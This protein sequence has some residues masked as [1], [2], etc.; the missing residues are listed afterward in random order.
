MLKGIIF[1]MDGTL[2][3]TNEY[4]AMAYDRLFRDFG[5]SVTIDEYF[6][7]F[8]GKGS[9]TIITEG[10]DG[11]DFDY[12]KCHAQKVK[13][14]WEIINDLEDVPLI[15]GV[16]DFLDWV[17]RSELRMVVASG[18]AKEAIMQVL[19]RAGIINY[20]ENYFSG[21]EMAQNKPAPDVYI[22]ALRFLDLEAHEVLAFEDSMAG[23]KSSTSAGIKTIGLTT[24]NM[25]SDL[26]S[27]GAI[28]II[29]D[30]IELMENI[31]KD[32]KYLNKY[33][34]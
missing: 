7:C 33:F 17:K 12:Q 10:L 8:L 29:D 3:R 11:L 34:N 9:H 13:Y 2:T 14:F 20:F 21:A 4:H 15:P 30:Y 27:L 25:Q 1:D 22:E 18:S 28:E 26:E 31:K 24:S 23:A 16:K 5:R 19:E 32:K 6:E